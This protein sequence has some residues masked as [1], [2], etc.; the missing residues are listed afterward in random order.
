MSLQRYPQ[1]DLA[2]QLLDKG[3]LKHF[4]FDHWIISTVIKIVCLKFI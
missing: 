2:L 4:S 3:T 1:S